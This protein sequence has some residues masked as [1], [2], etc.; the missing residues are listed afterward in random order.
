VESSCECGNE[1]LA[2]I[3]CWEILYYLHNCRPLKKGS[4]PWSQLVQNTIKEHGYFAKNSNSGS[5]IDFTSLCITSPF[6][7]L[8]TI[9]YKT[10]VQNM[11]IAVA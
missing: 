4:A 8:K 1:H 10:L 2:F 6:N 9:C 3:K 11:I 7:I 5:T